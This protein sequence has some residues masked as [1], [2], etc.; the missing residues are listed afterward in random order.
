L[1]LFKNSPPNTETSK[2]IAGKYHGLT[3]FRNA[4]IY[5]GCGCLKTALPTL[6]SARQLLA[7]TTD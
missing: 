1:R 7:N 6:K 5:I 2:T 4:A 3:A